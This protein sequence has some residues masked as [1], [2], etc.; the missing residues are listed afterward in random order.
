MIKETLRRRLIRGGLVCG[1]VLCGWGG[2]SHAQKIDGSRPGVY[3]TFK[4]YVKRAPRESTPQ[5]GARLVLHNNTRWPIYFGEWIEPALSGDVA[6]MYV[7][8]QDDGRLEIRR[9]V[10]VVTEGRVMPGKSVSFTAPREDFPEKGSIYVR[11][12][13]SWERKSGRA[14]RGEAQHRAYFR[15]GALPQGNRTK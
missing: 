6:V 5:E 9:H 3:L 8:E 11:F 2:D 12:E 15:S 4:E 10:D 7:I 14:L 13:Y 1:L